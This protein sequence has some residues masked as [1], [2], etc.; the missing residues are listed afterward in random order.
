MP[1][2]LDLSASDAK[3]ARARVHLETLR[4]EIPVAIAQRQPYTPRFS[5]IDPKSGW[6][7]LFLTA[8]NLGHG[9]GII[10]GDLVNNLRCALEY[11]IPELVTASGATLRTKHQFPM[12]TSLDRY[13]E[14][15]GTAAIPVAGGPLGGIKYGLQE[16]F[17]FQPFHTQPSP[18]CDLL[19]LVQRFSNADK[20]R[21]ISA[22]VPVPRSFS[23]MVEHEGKVLEES[24][25]PSLP[26][27]K[28]NIEFEIARLRF[29]KP[30]PTKLSLEGKLGVEILFSTPAFERDPKGLVIDVEAL[31]DMCEHVAVVTD[32][33]KK[34]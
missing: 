27:L 12:F 19:A 5:K 18:E 16:I 8:N 2:G 22:V 31:Q 29:A 32:R 26:D 21:I 10:V 3:L 6:C 23:A 28:P 24:R 30:Y 9:L 13:T 14:K 11:I 7:T 1:L 34:L 20:H 17:D 15:I 33:F 4:R 25:S